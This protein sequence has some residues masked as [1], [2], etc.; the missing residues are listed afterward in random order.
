MVGYTVPRTTAFNFVS[1]D[2]SPYGLH[3]LVTQL[4][5]CSSGVDRGTVRVTSAVYVSQK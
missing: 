5:V 3:L 4:H 2:H 1:L